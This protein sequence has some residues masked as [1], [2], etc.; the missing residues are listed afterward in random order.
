MVQWF[1]TENNTRR[2][3]IAS[4][5]LLKSDLVKWVEKWHV[6]G[7]HAKQQGKECLLSFY[8]YID[9]VVEAGITSPS[10]IGRRNEQYNLSRFMDAGGYSIGNCRFITKKENLLE[11]ISS[12]AMKRAAASRKISDQCR[13]I[14]IRI[15]TAEDSFVISG[16]KAAYWVTG[17][18]PSGLSR[19][20]SKQQGKYKDIFSRTDDEADF[21]QED[22]HNIIFWLAIQLHL[23]R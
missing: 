11:R 10:Q 23:N 17:I 1:V 15:K 14:N 20:M 18:F 13:R 12:G 19:I 22:I 8:E 9:L 5:G 21:S 3:Y 6:L 7:C 2:D 4:K 16:F